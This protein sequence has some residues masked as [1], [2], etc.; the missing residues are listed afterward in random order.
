ME[1]KT[2]RYIFPFS[3]FALVFFF[4][5]VAAQDDGSFV[6]KEVSQV[7]NETE[8][9]ND[10][11]NIDMNAM[12]ELVKQAT[13]QAEKASKKISRKYSGAVLE[14]L[15]TKDKRELLDE[16]WEIHNAYKLIDEKREILYELLKNYNS[17][18]EGQTER[19]ESL[20]SNFQK[21]LQ[22]NKNELREV[23]TKIARTAIEETDY[24]FSKMNVENLNLLINYLRLVKAR[25]KEVQ[26][27]YS[28]ANSDISNFF[29]TVK[30]GREAMG[31]MINIF[32]LNLE[33]EA[34][35]A[36]AND[37]LN[38]NELTRRITE[39][40]KNLSNSVQELRSV[41]PSDM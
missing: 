5:T 39:S 10:R 9:V 30:K 34:I 1:L 33:M 3:L 20:I 38:L 12:F 7:L 18:L 11:L 22:E 13:D 21:K 27:N 2:K 4:T 26:F 6:K 31:Y 8:T 24:E 23:E 35:L 14:E 36:R 29:H 41:S 28:K 19:I 15:S 37:M 40:L 17:S 32:E 25:I 16:L